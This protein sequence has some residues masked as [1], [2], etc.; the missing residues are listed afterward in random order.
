VYTENHVTYVYQSDIDLL[1]VLKKGKYAG[2]QAINLE[3]NIHKGLDKKFPI[4]ITQDPLVSMQEPSV[5]LILEPIHFVNN[6]L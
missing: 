6:Q 2:Y 1:L 5:T 3:H 4:D